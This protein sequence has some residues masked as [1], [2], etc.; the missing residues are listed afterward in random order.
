ML[1][2]FKAKHRCHSNAHLIDSVQSHFLL[3]VSFLGAGKRVFENKALEG[4]PLHKSLALELVLAVD[5]GG[6]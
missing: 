3:N 5:Q 6:T 1:K 4:M 2:Y